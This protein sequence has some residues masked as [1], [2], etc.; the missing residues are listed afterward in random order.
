MTIRRERG[1]DEVPTQYSR[2][3]L[4]AH[5]LTYVFKRQGCSGVFSIDASTDDEA[6][7]CAVAFFD[8]LLKEQEWQKTIHILGARIFETGAEYT[9]EEV[10]RMLADAE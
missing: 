3:Y 6:R 2:S 10:Q 4:E 8:A 5:I 9:D 1:I 7:R